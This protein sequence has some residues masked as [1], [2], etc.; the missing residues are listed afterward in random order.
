MK[1]RVLGFV[2]AGIPFVFILIF[3]GF[4]II[5]SFMYT[6]G[7]TGGPNKVVS[8]MA[9][10]QVVAKHGPTLGV[11]R[12]LWHSAAFRADFWST[13]WVTLVSVILL[14]IVS[15]VIAVYLRIS[16]GRLARVV[17]AIY[18][19]PMFI[20]SVIAGY[21]LLTFWEQNGYL[22]TIAHHLGDPNFPSFGHTLMGV[23]VGQVWTGL[24]FSVLMLA[25][26]LQSVPDAVMEAARDVGAGLWT[27]CWRILLPLNLLPTAI[28]TTFSIIGTLGAYTI[29]YLMGPSS[30]QLLGVAMT[31][32]YG[33]FNEPQQAE[34]MAVLLFIAAAFVGFLYVWANLRMDRKAGASK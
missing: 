5:Q 30:P 10:N 3:V 16:N 21:A 25:S 17:S 14:L 2:L 32:Y 20:P 12:E 31:T 27:V 26:G 7:F 6:L 34:A 9:Q 13:V 29:P 33:S 18:L 15:W 8:E 22:D 28:V 23:V 11:Y 4:P 24:P 19:I 1:Q